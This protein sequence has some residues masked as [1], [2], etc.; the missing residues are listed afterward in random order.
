[1]SAQDE[2]SSQRKHEILEVLNAFFAKEHNFVKLE[3]ILKKEIKVSLRTLEFAASHS[4]RFYSGLQLHGA[5]QNYLSSAGKRFFDAFKRH[6]KFTYSLG[7]RKIETNVAQLRFI[8]FAL[9]NGL[10][11]WLQNPDNARRVEIEMKKK[12]SK[13]KVK[14]RKKIE[15]PAVGEENVVLKP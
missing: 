13:K 12:M 5:Y 8:K 9:E 1:M 14:K 11:A 15:T 2:L 6:Q 3:K 10:V 4:H 7:T